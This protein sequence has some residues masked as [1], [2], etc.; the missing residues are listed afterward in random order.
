ML[1]FQ[2]T[3]KLLENKGWFNLRVCFVTDNYNYGDTDLE[4]YADRW[5]TDE[6]FQQKIDAYNNLVEAQKKHAKALKQRREEKDYKE[7]L[8]LKKKFEKNKKDTNSN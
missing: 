8:R 5:E 6:E 4:I 7:Y 3:F 2:K 1:L